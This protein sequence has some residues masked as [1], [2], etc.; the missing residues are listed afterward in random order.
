LRLEIDAL[1]ERTDGSVLST[2]T[3]RLLASKRLL[4]PGN[5]LRLLSEKLRLATMYI[6]AENGLLLRISSEPKTRRRRRRL[7]TLLWTL[8]NLWV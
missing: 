4:G 7:S 2:K 5:N 8:S 6:L 3:I 1:L